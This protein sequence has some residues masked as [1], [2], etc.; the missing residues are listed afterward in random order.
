MCSA[1]DA[2]R[3]ACFTTNDHDGRFFPKQAKAKRA[4]T[5]PITITTSSYRALCQH[6]RAVSYVVVQRDRFGREASRFVYVMYTRSVYVV[7]WIEAVVV[8]VAVC[9][10][11]FVG[12][13]V[14]V[15][16]RDFTAQKLQ[17]HRS[18][19][20]NT[21]KTTV[22]VVTVWFAV[23]LGRNEEGACTVHKVS[24]TNSTII[25]W[26]VARSTIQ[27][28]THTHTHSRESTTTTTRRCVCSIHVN[29]VIS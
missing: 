2:L 22:V 27:M 7:G 5:A 11:V 6:I 18:N 8:V 15:R 20:N 23:L 14:R 28:H 9:W 19:N 16:E 21:T 26:H 25:A 13:Q 29:S 4:A 3:C 10:W 24:D 12:L 1:A 17:Q